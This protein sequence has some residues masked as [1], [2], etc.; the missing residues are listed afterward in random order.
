M[1]GILLTRW[2]IRLALALYAL[3]LASRLASAPGERPRPW[4]RH[5]WTAA[6]ASF[7]VHLAAAM[8]FYHGWSHQ[9]AVDD[10]A[11]QTEA[12]L[13]VAFGEGIYFSYV[14]AALWLADVLWWWVGPASYLARGR[15]L[16]WGVHAYLFFI[17]FH[18][19]VV[20]ES[21]PTR[22]GGLLV[23]SILAALVLRRLVARSPLVPAARSHPSSP[24]HP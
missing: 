6:C 22:W 13:G 24:E 2:T 20:F 9:A 10:T 21:G 12:L 4:Q 5:V 8:H 18:G 1:P 15:W 3:Y 23:T 11:R 17:A 16:E 14:F 7:L 19:A